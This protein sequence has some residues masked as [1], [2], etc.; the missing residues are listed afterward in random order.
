[1]AQFALKCAKCGRHSQTK[2]QATLDTTALE[3]QGWTWVAVTD[4][5][6]ALQAW[7]LRC[8]QHRPK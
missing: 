5:K 7:E 2:P 1:M 6:G 8:P 4:A 3:A